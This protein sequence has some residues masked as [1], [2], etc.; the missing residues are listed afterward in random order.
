MAILEKLRSIVRTDDAGAESDAIPVILKDDYNEHAALP[1][2]RERM[3]RVAKSRQQ[4]SGRYRS[5]RQTSA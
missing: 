3:A 4:G 1:E 2:V 5:L